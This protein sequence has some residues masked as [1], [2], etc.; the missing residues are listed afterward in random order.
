MET[1]TWTGHGCAGAR[2]GN[3]DSADQGRRITR[4]GHRVPTRLRRVPEPLPGARGGRTGVRLTTQS[5]C[6]VAKQFHKRQFLLPTSCYL[7]LS[8]DPLEVHPVC[9][10]TWDGFVLT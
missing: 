5:G 2:S 10:M 4:S 6:L 9:P 1:T 3:G 7:A 8:P